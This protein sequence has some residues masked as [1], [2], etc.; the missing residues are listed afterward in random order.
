MLSSVWFQWETGDFMIMDNLAVAHW[1][2]PE[3]QTDQEDIGLRVLHKSLAQGVITPDK[4]YTVD[5]SRPIQRR[6]RP[7]K[8]DS[9]S[10]GYRTKRRRPVKR[11]L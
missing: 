5:R 11:E 6:E 9:E 4:G 3:S 10:G 7:R 2:K 1:V 8:T